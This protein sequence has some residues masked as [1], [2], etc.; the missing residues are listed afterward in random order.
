MTDSRSDRF[1]RSHLKTRHLVLLVELGRHGSIAHAAQAANLTQPGASKLLGE[2]EHALGVQL[3]ERLSRG[4]S[5][6]WYGKVL[7]RRAGAALA[8]MDAAH[9]EVMELLSGLRGR[10]GI[11]TVLAPAT[12]LVPKAIN[13]LKERHARVH[14]AVNMSTSKVLVERLRSGELDLVVGRILDTEAADELNFEPLT[15]EP[16]LL[17]ARASHPLMDRKELK[18]E[19]LMEQCWILPP[20]GSILRDRLTALFLSHGLEQPAETVETL[21]MPVVASLL[22][23]NDMVVAL[24]AEAVQPYLDAG[25]LKVLPFDLGVSMDSFGI[26]TRKR[27][28]LSPGADAMLTALRDAAASIYPHYRA[29]AQG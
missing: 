20:A 7:I 6:T 9:Q 3:F 23:N 11:G 28:Q 24:P 1:V 14:V 25:L 4:V 29:P 26:V 10:V 21:D 8:E 17:I 16:H 13:L 15:D 5:P 27:H 2:L 12:G 22:L 18:L 19:D